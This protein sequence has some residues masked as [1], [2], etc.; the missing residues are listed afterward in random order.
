MSPSA[1]VSAMKSLA[2]AQSTEI[3]ISSLMFMPTSITI[4]A[5]S[6]V[7]WTNDEPISHTVTSGKFTGVDTNTGLRSDQ[8]P[9][10]LFDERLS[11]QGDSFSYTYTTPG[12]YYYYCDVHYG[13]N[14][15]VIV[16]P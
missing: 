5:G 4:K 9:D 12:T 13:M 15:T 14:A 10:A 8:T 2:D 6:T 11:G 1:A 7:T 16:T 3:S